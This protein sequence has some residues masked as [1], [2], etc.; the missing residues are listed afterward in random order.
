[1]PRCRWRLGAGGDE[2]VRRLSAW[3]HGTIGHCAKMPAS[4]Y[5]PLLPGRLLRGHLQRCREHATEQRRA[6]QQL[7]TGAAQRRKSPIDRPRSEQEHGA[8]QGDRQ[9]PGSDEIHGLQ[10]PFRTFFA[11]RLRTR[12][13]SPGATSASLT[14]CATSSRASPPNKEPTRSATMERRTCGSLTKAR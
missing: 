9:Q 14:R 8:V 4:A 3:Q 10:S 12:S 13:R 2:L 11:S 6:P 5:L 7:P 1:M